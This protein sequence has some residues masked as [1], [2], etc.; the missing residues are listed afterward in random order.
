MPLSKEDTLFPS[1][2]SRLS[3]ASRLTEIAN[4]DFTREAVRLEVESFTIELIR[5]LREFYKWNKRE[6]TEYEIIHLPRRRRA[7]RDECAQRGQ[8]CLPI[9]KCV[10]LTPEARGEI[11]VGLWWV[12]ACNIIKDTP[13]NQDPYDEVRRVLD[14]EAV[15]VVRQHLDYLATVS[16]A[17]EGINENPHVGRNESPNLADNDYE[18]AQNRKSTTKPGSGA[19]GTT[20]RLRK[21]KKRSDK[22]ND[23]PP[24]KKATKSVYIVPSAAGSSKRTPLLAVL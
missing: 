9:P 2:R 1:L 23:A 14:E 6:G 13:K 17:E 16:A 19:G 18:P 15:P 10:Q 5:D 8:E 7:R 20:R 22:E 21:K 4:P 24:V 11:R 12:F 3:T